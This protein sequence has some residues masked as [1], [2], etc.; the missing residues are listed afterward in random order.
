MQ[1]RKFRFAED[2]L[3]AGRAAVQWYGAMPKGRK[4]PQRE[5]PLSPAPYPF[6][7]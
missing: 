1:G 6:I 2:F 4:G 3:S 7:T 5:L